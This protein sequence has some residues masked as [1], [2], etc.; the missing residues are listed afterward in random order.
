[1]TGGGDARK[2]GRE[3]ALEAALDEGLAQTFPASDPVAVHPLQAYPQA[4]VPSRSARR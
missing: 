4:L 2:R 1:M 3:A